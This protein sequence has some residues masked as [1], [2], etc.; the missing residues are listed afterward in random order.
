MI[1]AALTSK[2]QPLMQQ[3][4]EPVRIQIDALLTK[5]TQL[6][7]E[8]ERRIAIL[9]EER[10]LDALARFASKAD[11]LRDLNPNQLELLALEPGLHEAEL[12]AALAHPPAE[13][14]AEAPALE[15]QV[16]T[17]RY[18]LP[19]KYRLIAEKLLAKNKINC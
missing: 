16:K 4:A 11:R 9:E 17:K 2:I 10:R 15:A 19:A 18:K 12:D 14:Q 3:L 6:F 8:Q 13:Q 7:G 5:F 1:P